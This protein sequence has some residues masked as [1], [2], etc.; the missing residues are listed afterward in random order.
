[1]QKGLLQGVSFL[2]PLPYY[3]GLV[4]LAVSYALSVTGQLNGV[5]T[6]FTETEKQMV[7]MERA[8]HYIH[9]IPAEKS[10]YTLNVSTTLVF[11]AQHTLFL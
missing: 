4:G 2:S 11:C 1:M 8:D 10:W 5:V 9:N 7:S 6:M 3:V